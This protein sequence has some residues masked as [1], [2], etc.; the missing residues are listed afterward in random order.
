MY[1]FLKKV[2]FCKWNLEDFGLDLPIQVQIRVIMPGC[3][4]LQV[5]MELPGGKVLS[6][7]IVSLPLHLS[8]PLAH[9]P[10][11]HVDGLSK[12]ARD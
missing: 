12:K 9:L 4:R 1:L 6:P 7:F 10:Y 8:L 3:Y 11:W 5:S 2:I